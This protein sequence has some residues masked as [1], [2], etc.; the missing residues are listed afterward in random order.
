M[1][2]T[3]GTSE[4]DTAICARYMRIRC[5]EMS[6]RA[7]KQ[8]SDRLFDLVLRLVRRTWARK[9]RLEGGRESSALGRPVVVSDSHAG[10]QHL[11]P[12]VRRSISQRFVL[13][14]KPQERLDL[15]RERWH[16]PVKR[17]RDHDARRPQTRAPAIHPLRN[18]HPLRWC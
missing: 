5:G 18:D 1:S 6:R 13:D 12:C 8:E 14:E 17:Q 11:P 2:I 3:N 15:R 7:T 4:A 10:L 9:V 16:E